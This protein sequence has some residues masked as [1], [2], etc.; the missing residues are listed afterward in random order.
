MCG[1]DLTTV[2][3]PSKRQ[4][5]IKIED[6]KLVICVQLNAIEKGQSDYKASLS[7]GLDDNSW[8]VDF[9]TV[10]GRVRD[11][12]VPLFLIERFRVFDKNISRDFIFTA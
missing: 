4:T 3:Y 8:C 6:D 5:S 9:Y 2:F 11:S 7:F 1:K 10:D 12:Y